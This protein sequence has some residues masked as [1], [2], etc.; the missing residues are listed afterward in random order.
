MANLQFIGI[1]ICFLIHIFKNVY[2]RLMSIKMCVIQSFH[3]P[4]KGPKLLKRFHSGTDGSKN[5]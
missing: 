5:S 1:Y 4:G 2:V 3:T